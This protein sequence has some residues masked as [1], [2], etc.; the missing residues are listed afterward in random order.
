MKLKILNFPLGENISKRMYQLEIIHSF[1]SDLFG[2][3]TPSPHFSN[4]IKGGRK[5]ASRPPISHLSPL[6]RHPPT[7]IRRWLLPFLPALKPPTLVPYSVHPISL[8][9]RENY[10]TPFEA[11]LPYRVFPFP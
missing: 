10:S 11:C 1:T 7:D 6:Q 9:R 8:L 2:H 3:V 4:L 5:C